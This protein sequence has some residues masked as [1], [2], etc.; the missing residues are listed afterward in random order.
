[1]NKAFIVTR[2][3]GYLVRIPLYGDNPNARNKFFSTS[4]FGT[5]VNCLAEALAHRDTQ[6]ATATDLELY[7]VDLSTIIPAGLSLEEKH[8]NVYQNETTYMVRRNKTNKVGAALCRNFV[9]KLYPSDL[10]ALAHAIMYRDGG[11]EALA[12]AFAAGMAP[13]V[14]T[15]V[16]EEHLTKIRANKHCYR[17]QGVYTCA[18]HYVGM[19]PAKLRGTGLS[20]KRFYFAD[21][22]HPVDALTD[23]YLWLNESLSSATPAVAAGPLVRPNRRRL[24]PEVPPALEVSAVADSAEM[25]I[26]SMFCRPPAHIFA[27]GKSGKVHILQDD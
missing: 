14:P 11:D 25:S 5:L 13:H 18:D 2:P 20:L 24:K 15:P 8:C 26:L 21:Y 17:P 7:G 16:S 22:P 9:K 23:A 3:H 6:M 27:A 4:E 19:F 10:H 1:M 12:A